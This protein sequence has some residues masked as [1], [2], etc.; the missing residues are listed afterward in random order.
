MKVLFIVP[1]PTEGPSNRF[2][3]EQYLPGLSRLGIRYTV[4]PFC[5]SA[6]YSILPRKGMI[7]RKIF[8][9]MF[10][11]LLRIV[12][13]F[14]APAYDA[15]FIHREAFPHDDPLFELLFRWLGR[16]II[17]DF[18]DSLFLKKPLKVST[19]TRI[20]DHVIAGNGFLADYAL[21]L[22]ANVSI[23]PTCIDTDVYL[24]PADRG[25]KD[26]VV[27]GWIGTRTTSMYLREISDALKE[28]SV[29]FPMI[30]IRIV[31]S[32]PREPGDMPATYIDWSLDTELTEL[33]RFDI[34]IMPMPDNE[35][36]NGKCAF[37]LI[38]YMSV[39]IPS[40][41]SPVGMN[42][43]VL[44]SGVNGYFASTT[45]EW[46]DRISALVVSAE[47]REEMGRM[48]RKTAVE[49]FSLK[50]NIPHFLNILE[51]KKTLKR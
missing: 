38:Q 18:D 12:D 29:R 26:K 34:G 31:G 27:I 25:K 37:K 9:A 46:I 20:A 44:E 8:Y 2:R 22:N 16:R 42:R 23:L 5:H 21:K 28:L 50:N 51:Q 39:G 45:G 14:R 30:E 13:I 47:L 48:A 3:V 4:R 40:V 35:W 33:Q 17:Y 6:L 1:Y 10:S 41:V 7:I 24:P 36:T 11:M 32:A 15:V 49:R 43:E 19:V